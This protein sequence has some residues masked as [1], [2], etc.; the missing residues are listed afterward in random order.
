MTATIANPEAAAEARDELLKQ[1][2]PTIEAREAASVKQ[3]LEQRVREQRRTVDVLGE[4][5][6]FEPVGVGV[7]REAIRLRQRALDGSAEAEA[8]LIDLV[9]ETL[10]GHATDPEMDEDWWGQF[11]MQTI[12]E[13]FE[14]LVMTDV[15]PEER[16]QIEQF[17]DE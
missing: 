3:R 16:E 2:Q 1:T 6:E 11:Q 13:A 12:Q 17:R 10:A 15:S 8:G 4:P 9:F 5:V 7:S 14:Q